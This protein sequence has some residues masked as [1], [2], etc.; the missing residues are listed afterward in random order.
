MQKMIADR[1]F[2][3]RSQ[4]LKVGDAFD[5]DDEHV[6][7]FKFI[8]HAHVPKASDRDQSYLTRVMTASPSKRRKTV[9]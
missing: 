9:N 1:A 8:G 5:A 6:E 3:Y 2:T 4:S 7:L